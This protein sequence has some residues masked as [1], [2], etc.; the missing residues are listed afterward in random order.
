MGIQL[1][2]IAWGAAGVASSVL[3]PVLAA[4]VREAFP[5]ALAQGM[6]PWVKPY[7]LL[8][9]F[10]FVAATVSIIWWTDQ[11]PEPLTAQRAFLIG[12]AWETIS[13]K[14]TQPPMGSTPNF[15]E[16][17]SGGGS[18]VLLLLAVAVVGWA[19]LGA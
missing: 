18:L 10:S 8:A 16:A 4:K 5:H 19:L 17:R 13:E 11:H 1:S 3:L 12:F 6:P 15:A 9:V 14:L 2:M 7:A